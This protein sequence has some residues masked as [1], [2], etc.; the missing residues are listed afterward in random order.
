MSVLILLLSCL[1]ICLT[2]E[3]DDPPQNITVVFVIDVPSQI[4]FNFNPPREDLQ[5]GYITEYRV[6]CVDRDRTRAP[7]SNDFPSNAPRLYS[8][9]G[10]VP[11][12]EYDCSLSAS[13]SVGFGAAAS[14][15][16]LTCKDTYCV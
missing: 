3:P 12:T 2:T 7:V 11:A 10:L 6:S 9:S 1:C 14:V 16:I 8:L 5:N 4:R 13:T 15:E